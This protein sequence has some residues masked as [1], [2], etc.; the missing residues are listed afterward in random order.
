MS[1]D[2][3]VP[4]DY[5]RSLFDLSGRVAVVT[6]AGSGLGAAMA[7]GYARGE[8]VGEHLAMLACC[9]PVGQPNAQL[10]ERT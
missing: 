1:D 9:A 3:A 2:A 4:V 6:G 10:V 8:T 5:A 7:I